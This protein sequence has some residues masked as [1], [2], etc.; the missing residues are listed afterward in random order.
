MS[1]ASRLVGLYPAPFRQRW[2]PELELQVREAGPRA[3]PGVVCGVVDMWLHPVVW[4]AENVDR[5]LSRASV[6]AVS[7]TVACW[8][9]AHFV[10]EMA[11]IRP[12][13]LDACLVLMTIGLVL[14]TP[15]PRLT[16]ANVALLVRGAAAPALLATVV[17]AAVHLDV[18]GPVLRFTLLVGWYLALATG[19][20][21]SCRLLARVTA[22]P[23]HP[24]R[25]TWGMWLLATASASTA[26]IVAAASV[27]VGMLILLIAVASVGTIHDVR[28]VASQPA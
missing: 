7:A 28:N 26:C 21:Q 27:P 15:R 10:A 17:V 9:F 13:R 25:L 14:V 6:L 8:Y 4:P 1:G 24:R 2:G 3:W 20:V 11:S 19:A 18:T 5:R 23:P 22:D 12:G 16:I